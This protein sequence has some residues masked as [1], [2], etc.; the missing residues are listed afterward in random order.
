MD[1]FLELFTV[2]KS[3]EHG[4]LYNAP[5]HS[6]IDTRL[7]TSFDSNES[8]DYEYPILNDIAINSPLL[9]KGIYRNHNNFCNK[10]FIF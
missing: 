8:T 3:P 2:K 7:V 4:V 6:E 9:S 1:A 5:N 10:K